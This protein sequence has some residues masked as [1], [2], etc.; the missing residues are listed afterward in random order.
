[1]LHLGLY[2]QL[3]RVRSGFLSQDFLTLVFELKE[4]KN[5]YLFCAI[6]LVV[7]EVLGR[8]VSQYFLVTA[9]VCFYLELLACVVVRKLPE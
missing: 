7:L 9:H 3:C 6:S 8:V 4:K 1:M 2:K 5:G